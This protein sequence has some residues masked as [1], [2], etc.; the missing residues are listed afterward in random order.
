MMEDGRKRH[1]WECLRRRLV[2]DFTLPACKRCLKSGIDCPGYD[3]KEPNR[4]K[5]LAP[6]KVK[7]RTRK[8]SRTSKPSK[9]AV[10]SNRKQKETSVYSKAEISISCEDVFIPSFQLKTEVHMLFQAC[11]YYNACIYPSL[12]PT[13]E[14]GPRSNVYLISPAIFQKC[15]AY[16]DYIRL[17]IVCVTTSHLM[18][19]IRDNAGP[20]DGQSNPL[21]KTFF[22]Y[23]GLVIRSLSNEINMGHKCASDFVVAGILML[24]L[25]DTQHGVSPFWRCHLQGVQEIILLRGGIR[26]L[27]GSTGTQPLLLCFAYLGVIGDTCSPTPD[28]IMA[29]SLLDELDASLSNDQDGSFAAHVYP[30]TLFQEIIKIN[31]IRLRVSKHDSP[32]VAKDF[33]LEA[34]KT[35]NRIQAFSPETWAESKS[36]AHDDWVLLSEAMPS[37]RLKTF[38]LWPLIVLGVAAVH[39]SNNMRIFV[40]KHLE[41]MS[42]NLGTYIPLTGKDVLEGFWASGRTEWDACFDKPYAFVMQ[43]SVDVSKLL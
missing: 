37:P 31:L 11:Q 27:A 8:S 30:T 43:A 12:L 2:C 14:L 33:T 19:Q 15:L 32:D 21:A 39:N 10:K 28:L 40:I 6:G 20:F 22:R 3:E 41:E 24:L 26:T 9:S 7:S 5:W 38:F 42:R 36:S 34:F 13:T 1:C 4:L 35:L 29:P 18:N 25:V 16:P 23:R 17:S